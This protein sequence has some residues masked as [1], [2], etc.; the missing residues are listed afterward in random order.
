LLGF[1][2]LNF[3]IAPII[4]EKGNYTYQYDMYWLLKRIKKASTPSKASVAIIG[5]SCGS[6]LFP[7]EQMQET[8]TTS[9]AQTC[10]LLSCAAS[11]MA[12]HYIIAKRALMYNKNL[13]YIIITCS[14]ISIGIKFEQL[15]I[16]QNFIKPFF[17]FENLGDISKSIF[18]KMG[19]RPL[20]YLLVFPA[21][22]IA[23]CYDDIKFGDDLGYP[24]YTLSDIAL[25]YLIKIKALS[26]RYNVKVIIIP[27]PAGKEHLLASN[28]WQAM[29][30]QIKENN[31]DS[32]FINYFEN[33]IYIDSENFRDEVHLQDSYA[34][35]HRGEILKK[36]VPDELKYILSNVMAPYPT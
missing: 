31:L 32:L 11:T 14:P 5:D 33:I 23:S 36:V 27:T 1:G 25:E 30:K 35:E 29:R 12:G 21:V 13:K 10:N 26:E 6:Q 20:S 18:I 15:L 3:I 4:L 17:S 9:S 34:E 19:R 24:Y 28:N 7:E 8:L 16:F 2:L 22:K